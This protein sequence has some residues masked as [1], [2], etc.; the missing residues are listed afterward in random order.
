MRMVRVVGFTL[1]EMLLVMAIISMFIVMGLNYFQQRTLN[2]RLDKTAVQM[3]QILNAG[4]SYYV[5]NGFWPADLACL[6]GTTSERCR[7]AYLPA[8]V[9]SNL[10]S[11]QDYVVYTG[12]NPNLLFVS[13]NVYRSDLD[14]NTIQAYAALIASKL[15]LACTTAD[16][17][18]DCRAPIPAC[19]STVCNVVS[20]INVPGENL[21]NINA[22]RF[23]SLYHAGACVPE[24]YCP[25]NTTAQIMVAP[26]SVAGVGGTDNIAFPLTSFTAYVAGAV[27]RYTQPFPSPPG[28]PACGVTSKVVQQPCLGMDPSAT[29]RYWRVCMELVTSAGRSVPSTNPIGLGQATLLAITRC[30]IANEPSGSNFT[31]WQGNVE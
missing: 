23:A 31:V 3:Q 4:L 15:P 25:P 27:Q 12:T 13:T 22:V 14:P 10:I 1:F 28:P 24:P 18:S 8:S 20:S 21:S 16:Q 11:N 26:S 17:R 5:S 7:V 30:A 19:K 29:G 9:Q 6:K 2:L